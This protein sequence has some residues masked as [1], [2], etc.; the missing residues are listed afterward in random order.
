MRRVGLGDRCHAVLHEGDIL[1]V[2]VLDDR[3]RGKYG[4]QMNRIQFY[5][6]VNLRNYGMEDLCDV[7]LAIS[8]AFNT[9][10]PVWRQC[11][12]SVRRVGLG[13]RC[14]AILHEGNIVVVMVLDDQASGKYGLEMHG[15]TKLTSKSTYTNL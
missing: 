14:H 12:E 7:V 15:I 5:K 2:V 6:H 8:Q 4:L 1:V 3:A 9:K 13:D 10:S 11:L